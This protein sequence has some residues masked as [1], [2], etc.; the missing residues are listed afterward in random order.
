M[1]V[2][3]NKDAPK[4]NYIGLS[5]EERIKQIKDQK[6]RELSFA[7]IKPKKVWMVSPDGVEEE[8]LWDNVRDFIRLRSY[9]IKADV[10][11]KIV[12]STEDPKEEV[13]QAAVVDDNMKAALA[14]EEEVKTALDAM[15]GLRQTLQ[16]LG[17]EPDLRWGHRRLKDEIAKASLN[18]KITKSDPPAETQE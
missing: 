9:T 12:D 11:P 7:R 17:V 16:D 5:E 1:P 18:R 2:V 14:R 4:T 6:I 10:P 3:D 8:V 15:N 13:N